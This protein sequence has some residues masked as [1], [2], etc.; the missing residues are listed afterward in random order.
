MA[1]DHIRICG[2]YRARMQAPRTAKTRC[3][4][5]AYYSM[6]P[7]YVAKLIIIQ[8]AAT[9]REGTEA[10]GEGDRQGV[11]PTLMDEVGRKHANEKEK[12]DLEEGFYCEKSPHFSSAADT[13]T[14]EAEKEMKKGNNSNTASKNRK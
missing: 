1:G 2:S 14:Q 4:A 6:A 9:R 8:E 13:V 7:P 11:P 3:V 12:G 10:A 5:N